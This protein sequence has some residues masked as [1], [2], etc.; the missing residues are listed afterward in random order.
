MTEEIKKGIKI[1]KLLGEVKTV[2]NVKDD[3]EHKLVTGKIT[4]LDITYDEGEDGGL[5]GVIRYIKVDGR[6]ISKDY[7][8]TLTILEPV[9]IDY[10]D[11]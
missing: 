2:V 3:G 10:S 9:L 8:G 1:S 5:V 6:L 11:K 4:S 7:K